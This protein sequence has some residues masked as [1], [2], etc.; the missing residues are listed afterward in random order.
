MNIN[1]RALP[2][3]FGHELFALRF[4][5]GGVLW[6]HQH[7]GSAQAVLITVAQIETRQTDGEVKRD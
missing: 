1:L 2:V 6:V 3:H 5:N 4:E 7:L